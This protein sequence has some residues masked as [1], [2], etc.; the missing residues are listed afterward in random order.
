[1][2]PATTLTIALITV[3]GTGGLGI[4]ITTGGSWQRLR[5]SV[6]TQRY[7][8][9]L[10][11]ALIYTLAVGNG[12]RGAAILASALAIQAAREAAPLLQLKQLYRTILIGCC[13]LMPLLLPIAGQWSISAILLIAL[14]LPIVRGR[15]AELELAVKLIF[16]VLLIGWTLAHLVLLAQA[17]PA[18]LALALLGTAVSDVC[19]FTLGSLLGGPALTP[20]ISPNKTWSGLIGNLGGA[21]LALLLIA[22]M[23]PDLSWRLALAVIAIIGCGGCLG[24]LAESLLKRWAGV[25]DAGG[26]LPGFGGL[27]DRIDSLLIVAPLLAALLALR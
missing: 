17:G 9:W 23:L 24:D 25:K 8:S 14:V 1:M 5:H 7:L 26:W 13:G 2:Q 4:L 20:R 18:W 12:V 27:L 19:A 15:V 22:P 11:L 10:A 6:L 3:F 16:G 21:T